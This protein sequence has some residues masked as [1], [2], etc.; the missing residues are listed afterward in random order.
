MLPIMK[1][2]GKPRTE[3][4]Q[5]LDENGISQSTFEDWSG[6]NKNSVTSLCGNFDY[7]PPESTQIK[8]ISALRKR[9]F[10][11]SAGDFWE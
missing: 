11:V 4:G 8:A 3:F 6:I 10:Q 2:G 5:F 1:F 7:N 9:G